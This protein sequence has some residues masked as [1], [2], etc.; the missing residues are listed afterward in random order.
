VSLEQAD[1]MAKIPKDDQL[2]THDPD[3]ERDCAQLAG[4]GDGLPEPA[5]ILAARC[6][7]PDTSQLLVR[8]GHLPAVIRSIGHIQ[9]WPRCRHGADISRSGA[10][11]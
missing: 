8:R 7:G 6:A 11:M 10:E 1:T 5:E 4:E 9:K 3:G 2:L